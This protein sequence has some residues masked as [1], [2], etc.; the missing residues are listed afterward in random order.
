VIGA[1]VGFLLSILLP[2]RYEAA[3]SLLINYDYTYTSEGDLVIED[4]VLDR[5]WHLFVSDETYSGVRDKLITTEGS[6]EAWESVEALRD[7]SRLDARLSRW[8]FVGIHSDPEVAV[9]IANA[10]QRVARNRLDESMDHAWKAQSLPG[11]SFD[12]A[13]V[14]KVMVENWDDVISCISTGDDLSQETID[15]LRKELA[16]SH[17]ILPMITY[18]P[19]QEAQLP[20]SPVLWPRGLLIF[21]GGVIGFVLGFLSYILPKE[22]RIGK[23]SEAVN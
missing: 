21:S 7:H 14:E 13:C 8:E 4:R 22:I 15:Q 11:F 20:E 19:F 10:W 5:V 16:A 12:V 3:A 6:F 1:L 9:L 2:A 23:K 18:E 17:G